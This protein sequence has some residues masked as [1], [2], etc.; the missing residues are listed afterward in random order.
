MEMIEVRSPGLRPG[1]RAQVIVL[2]ASESTSRESDTFFANLSLDELAAQ[3]GITA[4][5]SFKKILGGWPDE[6]RND[7]FERPVSRWRRTGVVAPKRR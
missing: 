5:T 3:Q 7:G 1:S 6:E 4:P 2:E